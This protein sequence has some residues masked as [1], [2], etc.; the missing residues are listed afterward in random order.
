MAAVS[1]VCYLRLLH[2]KDYKRIAVQFA[3]KEAV[4]IT[5]SV[6]VAAEEGQ[7]ALTKFTWEKNKEF[8]EKHKKLDESTYLN[9]AFFERF[10]QIFSNQRKQIFCF[11]LP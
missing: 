3:N 9:R 5:I 2:Y 6:N 1:F 4:A 11:Y 10:R 8:Y 7:D